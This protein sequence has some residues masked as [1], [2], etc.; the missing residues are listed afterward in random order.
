MIFTYIKTQSGHTNCNNIV[1]WSFF[2]VVAVLKLFYLQFTWVQF[3]PYKI[4]DEEDFSSLDLYLRV[5]RAVK[6]IAWLLL[7][8]R[9]SSFLGFRCGSG[10]SRFRIWPLAAGLLCLVT[11]AS[12]RLHPPAKIGTRDTCISQERG[13]HISILRI[14]IQLQASIVGGP[15]AINLWA[16]MFK[17]IAK[18]PS[19][20]IV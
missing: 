3:I 10:S 13:F 6:G 7:P 11:L 19:R 14:R 1:Y 16:I 12:S 4:R 15:A 2:G 20:R 5:G 17:Q 8:R 18:G 9:W